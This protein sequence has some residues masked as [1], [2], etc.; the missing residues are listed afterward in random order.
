M[1]LPN[2]ISSKDRLYGN[3]VVEG[4]IQLTTD[5]QL[6][7]SSQRDSTIIFN[8]DDNSEAKAVSLK[9]NVGIKSYSVQCQSY[10]KKYV[11]I[12][13]PSSTGQTQVVPI[14]LRCTEIIPDIFLTGTSSGLIDGGMIAV[15]YMTL[16]DSGN[17]GRSYPKTSHLKWKIATRVSQTEYVL[18]PS[19]TSVDPMD[20]STAF[21]GYLCLLV[22]VP[23]VTNT[24]WDVKFTCGQSGSPENSTELTFKVK[25]V[26]AN[27]YFVGPLSIAFDNHNFTGFNLNREYVDISGAN[28][29]VK[30]PDLNNRIG[31]NTKLNFTSLAGYDFRETEVD[32]NVL[33]GGDILIC[34]SFGG[35]DCELTIEGGQFIAKPTTAE[36]SRGEM[37]INVIVE[38]LITGQTA[39]DQIWIKI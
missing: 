19:G 33:Y 23:P 37:Y 13:T 8:L 20:T 25:G 2:W 6:P 30:F 39:S 38:D 9:Q 24:T 31:G 34:P 18:G 26:A 35:S 10:S 12:A 28:V 29:L 14:L 32:P 4:T 36:L 21:S 5:N 11:G 15:K 22:T 17:L 27:D 7:N 3:K 1:G 16:A